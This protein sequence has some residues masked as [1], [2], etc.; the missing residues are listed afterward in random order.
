MNYSILAQKIDHGGGVFMGIQKEGKRFLLNPE[1][2][3]YLLEIS[4]DGLPVNLHW[5]EKSERSPILRIL[6][7]FAIFSTDP[8]SG[9]VS[10]GRNIQDGTVL[11]SLSRL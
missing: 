3:S 9:R 11:C 10:C 5:E 2:S 1:G 6:T 8:D 4:E 7:A